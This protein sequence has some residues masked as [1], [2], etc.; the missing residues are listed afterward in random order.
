MTW[1]VYIARRRIEPKVF[2][3]SQGI[4]TYESLAAW[5]AGSNVVTPPRADVES[6]L[7]EQPKVEARKPRREKGEAVVPPVRIPVTPTP[8]DDSSIV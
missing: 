2:L 3:A 8:P 4:A 1:A 6:L 7:P 5:C